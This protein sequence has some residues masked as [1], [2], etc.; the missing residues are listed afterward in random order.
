MEFGAHQFQHIKL[1]VH[2]AQ[3]A[4]MAVSW[5]LCIAVFRSSATDMGRLGWYFGLVG[6]QFASSG[7][8]RNFNVFA[9]L[10]HNP[11]NHLPNNDPPI[12]TNPQVR[13]SIRPG[14]RRPCFLRSMALGFRCGSEL[15]WN[16]QV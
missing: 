2:I 5:C 16:W 3:A 10:P 11:S 7:V 12:P 6:S 9:G 13:Q 8:I 14:R 4:L 1:G 15:E